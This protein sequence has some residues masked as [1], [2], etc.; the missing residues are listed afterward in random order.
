LLWSCH[1]FEG[2]CGRGWKGRKDNR[3]ECPYPH[4]SRWNRGYR[5]G[6]WCKGFRIRE[7]TVKN[8]VN[9][10][11]ASRHAGGLG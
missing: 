6:S 3:S 9:E 8:T 11:R 7:K 4:S 10:N 5:V 1:K 2:G